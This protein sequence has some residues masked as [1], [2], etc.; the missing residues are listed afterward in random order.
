MYKL[1]IIIVTQNIHTSEDVRFFLL[2]RP[3]LM[4]LH[5]YKLNII[6]DTQNIHT[7]EDVKFFLL[8]CPWL[9]GVTYL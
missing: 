5:I 3:L 8:N 2:N 6:I 7:S 9:F 1:N 4:E